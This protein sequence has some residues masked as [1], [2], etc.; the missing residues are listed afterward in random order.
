MK[1]PIMKFLS[2]APA[3]SFAVAFFILDYSLL[4]ATK[5]LIAAASAEVLIQFVFFRKIE[6]QTAIVW[7]LICFFGGLSLVLQDSIYIQWKTTVIFTGMALLILGFSRYQQAYYLQ[8]IMPFP[9]TEAAIQL[10]ALLVATGFLVAAVGNTYAL[11]YLSEA[12]W[13]TVKVVILPIWNTLV[14][15][16]S[17]TYVIVKYKIPIKP[18]EPE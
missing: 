9:M 6:R 15:I 16:G 8:K 17:F 14:L 11:I 3:I 1:K 12:Q 5:V 7:G 4:D 13:V 18:P 10:L 2:V